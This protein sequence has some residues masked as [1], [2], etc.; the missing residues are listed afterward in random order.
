[1]FLGLMTSKTNIANFPKKVFILNE[2]RTIFC[3]KVP[4]RICN[5]KA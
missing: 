1:M 5:I 2:K 3:R 4:L